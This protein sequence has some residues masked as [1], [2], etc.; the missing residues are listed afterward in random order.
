MGSNL[1]NILKILREKNR[2]GQKNQ[3]GLRRQKIT[4][5]NK[6]SNRD[7][8]FELLAYGLLFS[9]LAYVVWLLEKHIDLSFITLHS[10]FLPSL[11]IWIFL[12]FPYVK[13]GFFVITRFEPPNFGIWKKYNFGKIF[14]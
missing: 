3:T 13:I 5:H 4:Y 7:M 8:G 11:A 14:A 12:I 6:S 10:Y 9:V 1:S 2:K